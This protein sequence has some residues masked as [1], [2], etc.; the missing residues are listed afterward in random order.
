MCGSGKKHTSD[1]SSESERK[2]SRSRSLSKEKEKNSRALRGLGS[3]G[4]KPGEEKESSRFKR[5]EQTSLENKYGKGHGLNTR[6]QTKRQEAIRTRGPILDTTPPKTVRIG[7]VD[8][9]VAKLRPGFEPGIENEILNDADGKLCPKCGNVMDRTKGLQ[10]DHK[11]PWADLKIQIATYKVCKGGVHW[12]V[13]LKKDALAEYNRRSNLQAMH[14]PCNASKN[15]P[16]GNDE[17]V[18]KRLTE[19]CPGEGCTLPKAK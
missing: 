7:G 12:D 17:L 6:T 11:T 1:S 5:R 10:V 4:F 19:K 9:P 16:R 15:G 13:A 2:R 8:E 18:P 14:G 3:G